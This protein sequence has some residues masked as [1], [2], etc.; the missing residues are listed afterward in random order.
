MYGFWPNHVVANQLGF[1]PGRGTDLALAM[2]ESAIF[3]D[4]VSLSGSAAIFLD[5]AR[6]FPTLDQTFLRKVLVQSRAPVWFLR[7]F[8]AFYEKLTAKFLINGCLS[9]SFSLSR[10]LRQGCA[11]SGLLFAIASDPLLRWANARLPPESCLV[12]FADDIACVLTRMDSDGPRFLLAFEN[13]LKMVAGLNLHHHKIAAIAL[14]PDVKGRVFRVMR[15]HTGDWGAAV[16]RDHVTYLGFGVGRCCTKEAWTRVIKKLE[17]RASL[18]T[19]VPLGAPSLL[20]VARNLLWAI[21]N[22]MLSVMIPDGSL[23]VTFERLCNALFR[24]PSGWLPPKARKALGFIGWSA[25]PPSVSEL[26]FRLRVRAISRHQD[27][28]IVM[29]YERACRA[30]AREDE[31]LIPFLGDWFRNS[32]IFALGE[33]ARIGLLH[34]LFSLSADGRSVS[35]SSKMKR[36]LSKPK[37]CMKLLHET[38]LREG[39]AVAPREL[40]LI[41]WFLRRSP[42]VLGEVFSSLRA[43]ERMMAHIR[44][45]ARH[46]PPR[47]LNAMTRL[48]VDGVLLT[49]P[50]VSEKRCL[51]CLGCGGENSMS[52]YVAPSGS[53][54][55]LTGRDLQDVASRMRLILSSGCTGERS[56]PG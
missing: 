13:C 14:H 41:T 32:L 21:A 25:L 4:D 40:D 16:E 29:L 24:G 5:I 18:M 39:S 56:F 54:R 37:A 6:A 52:H 42:R 28:P 51:L 36:A 22:H 53:S 23:E 31:F 38:L 34:G 1:L 46:V 9:E 50:E 35:L 2:I 55:A 7:A 30:L 8:D 26:S 15:E 43:V 47:V 27:W 11:L 33:T 19:M 49:S 48:T 3:R 44:C 12:S 17:A 10:G 45:A 20:K